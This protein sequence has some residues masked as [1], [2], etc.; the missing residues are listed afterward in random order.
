MPG[1]L[2][3]AVGH[4]GL[5]RCVHMFQRRN[6]PLGKR[7]GKSTGWILKA[8][9]RTAG[10]AKVSGA[11]YVAIDDE[12]LHYSVEG[13]RRVLE[14]DHVVLCA[15]QNSNR[16]LYDQ[17]IEVGLSPRIIGGADVASEL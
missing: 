8:K 5:K 14:V 12:G 17:L 3:T 7:L 10:V 13:E 4:A 11:V 1:G 2:T 9:L 16:D 6:E 15:G